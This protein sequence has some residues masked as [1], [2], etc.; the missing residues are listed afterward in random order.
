MF[1][2]S[3]DRP[4]SSTHHTPTMIASLIERAAIYFESDR[5]ASRECLF[6]AYSLLR[7]QPGNQDASVIDSTRGMLANWQATRVIAYVEANLSTAIR[8]TDLAKLVNLSTSHFS[9]AFKISVGVPPGEYIARR[10]IDLARERM[11]TTDDPLSQI[12]L[13]CGLAEQSSFCR[14]FRRI[15]GQSPDRWRRANTIRSR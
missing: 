8:A 10:R 1:A 2:T 6:R 11:R 13:D 15:V 12:A 9:R 4:P 7:A 14:S 5:V 3:V